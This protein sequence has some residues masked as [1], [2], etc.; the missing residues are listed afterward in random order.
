MDGY[1]LFNTLRVLY[2]RKL[3]P[4]SCLSAL[5]ALD[6][7][8]HEVLIAACL[9]AARHLLSRDAEFGV[10]ERTTI[11][12]EWRRETLRVIEEAMRFREQPHLVLTIGVVAALLPGMYP[13]AM[14]TGFKMLDDAIRA[15]QRGA[16]ALKRERIKRHRPM[17]EL[18][19]RVAVWVGPH[20]E[21]R[22]DADLNAE[23]RAA[24]AAQGWREAWGAQFSYHAPRDVLGL[25][26]AVLPI[27]CQI[28]GYTVLVAP[29]SG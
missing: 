28:S 19:A 15:A 8:E 10:L 11:W 2:M 17:R 27:A 14:L 16:I 6:R 29:A 18:I 9:C 25:V 5:N 1:D 23:E 20:G 3:L 24:L 12:D 13:H 22:R 21:L 26:E 7:P 4:E